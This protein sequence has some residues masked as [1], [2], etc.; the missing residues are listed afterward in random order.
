[1]VFLRSCVL[2]MSYVHRVGA[3]FIAITVNIGIGIAVTVTVNIGITQKQ[4]DVNLPVG[5]LNII[6]ALAIYNH[7]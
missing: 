1:M 4:V 3:I 5:I 7:T 6:A 2:H